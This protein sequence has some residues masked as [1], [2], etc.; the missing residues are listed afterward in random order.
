MPMRRKRGA[1]EQR[2]VCADDP[3]AW[4][5]VRVYA[6]AVVVAIALGAST[7]VPRDGVAQGVLIAPQAVVIDSRTR[8]GELTL[9]NQGDTPVEVAISTLY[10]Y[11]VTDSEGAMSLHTFEVVPDTAPSAADWVQVF[12]RRL[13]LAP[14][15][16]QTLRVLVTPPNG[17]VDREYWARIVVAVRAGQIPVSG[18]SSGISAG[19]MLE[20]RSVLGFFYRN[21]TVSTGVTMQHATATLVGDSIVARATLARTGNAAFV[22][23]MIAIVRNASGVEVARST[24]PLGVYYTLAPR[25]AV[26]LPTGRFPAGKYSV[27]L[28]AVSTRP[29]VSPKLLLRA[30]TVSQ[31]VEV[32]VR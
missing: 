22:G 14:R 1:S 4:S 15:S 10:G 19:L 8:T 26:A 7:G 9:V 6:Y 5:W 18:G 17:L 28:E 31:T 24:V 12:P 25:V 16:R 21:G 2:A 30:P 32:V 27:T 3:R 23:S 29:D 20:V 13:R 11:P